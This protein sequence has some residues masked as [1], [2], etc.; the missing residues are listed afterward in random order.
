MHSH[1]PLLRNSSPLLRNSSD[2]AVLQS[3]LSGVGDGAYAELAIGLIR[4]ALTERGLRALARLAMLTSSNDLQRV[5]HIVHAAYPPA[6]DELVSPNEGASILGVSRPTAVSWAL[7]G[8]LTDQKVGNR[9]RFNRAEGRATARSTPA[10]DRGVPDR[11]AAS[12]RSDPI[13]VDNRE[14]QLSSPLDSRNT[15]GPLMATA[16]DGQSLSASC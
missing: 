13:G 15:C 5:E 10:D 2:L 7:T 4:V 6:V 14:A 12:Y 11:P 8:Q 9:H 3:M 16:C 1:C